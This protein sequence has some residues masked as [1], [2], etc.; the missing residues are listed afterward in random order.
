MVDVTVVITCYNRR[1]QLQ[2]ALASF[3]QQTFPKD[4]FEVIV[5]DDG[6]T[7]GVLNDIQE[8]N[9]KFNLHLVQLEENQGIS[10]A[11]NKGIQ[12]SK[13]KIIVFSDS[14]MIVPSVFLENHWKMHQT[15]EKRVVSAP[16]RRNIYTMIYPDQ[17]KSRLWQ[18]MTQRSPVLQDKIPTDFE[19]YRGAVPLFSP[20]DVS[21]G[22]ID[23]VSPAKRI[24]TMTKF[25]QLFGDQLQT[26]PMPWLAF[27]GSNTSVP[28][29][30]LIEVGGFDKRFRLRHDDREIG[31]RLYLSGHRFYLEEDIIGIHQD[32]FREKDRIKMQFY[33]LHD[34]AL[35][36]N[37]H[38]H[39]D[40]YLF[41]LY[42]TN[43][44]TFNPIVLAMIKKEM[45]QIEKLGEHGKQHVTRME[46]LLRH[47]IWSYLS[48][49]LG[50]SPLIKIR[51]PL[52]NQLVYQIW[53]DSLLKSK[54]NTK[55]PHFI[56]TANYLMQ[57]INTLNV[58]KITT[59]KETIHS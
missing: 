39:R 33:S 31:Y 57:N 13:G 19:T 29:E 4:R 18:S 50:S 9:W 12:K 46:N 8:Q 53:V 7:D 22:V 37:I 1:E 25:K 41:G 10:F 43:K 24:S 44:K 15:D 38:P 26:C 49:Y 47:Y 34:L 45:N 2:Y 40:I 51:Y 35:M 27:A 30:S 17:L 36:L 54:H 21:N 28:R 55:Y 48:L 5:V 6:S 3:E 32:H 20:K 16:C 52:G 42:Q 56:K 14:D 23:A 58:E 59:V 11:R